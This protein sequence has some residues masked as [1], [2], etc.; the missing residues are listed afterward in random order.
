MKKSGLIFGGLLA[1]MM[2]LCAGCANTVS[3]GE[4][5]SAGVPV[6]SVTISGNKAVAVG[7]SIS[8]Q[9]TVSPSNATV[10]T[11]SWTSSNT[12]AATVS[13]SGSRATVTGVAA[14][15]A[16]IT[17]A[18]TDGSGKKA[19]WQVT[20]TSFTINPTRVLLVEGSTAQISLTGDAGG[21]SWTSSNT[22]VATVSGSGSQATVTG[23][24]AGTAVITAATKECTATCEIT[25]ESGTLP[26]ETWWKADEYAAGDITETTELGIMTAVIDN[27]NNSLTIEN[28][29]KTIE[30]IVFNARLKTNGSG[31]TSKRALKFNVSGPCTV[32]VYCAS[33]NSTAADR[34]LVLADDNGLLVSDNCAPVEAGTLVYDYTGTAGT[35][36]L[37]SG[38]RG[39][40]IYGVKIS[41]TAGTAGTVVAPSGIAV[42]KTSLGFDLSEGN[43]TSTLTATLQPADVTAGYDGIIW[44]SD[45]PAVATVDGNGKT[46]LVRA[47][48]AGTAVITATTE[49]GSFSAGCTV[50]VTGERT[51]VIRASDIPSGYASTGVSTSGFGGYGG[52]VVTVSSK[53]KLVEYAKKSGKYVIY[54][55]GMID[56]S[57]G[58]LPAEGGGSTTALDEFVKNNSNSEF[59]TYEAFKTAY[60]GACSAETDDSSSSSPESTYG[61]VLWTLNKAYKNVIQLNLTSDKTLIGLGT[62][63]G[64]K[65]GTVSIADA[66][67]IALRNLTIQ[68]A[69]DPFPHYESGDGFNA[70]HD[71]IGIQGTCSNIWIDH[72]TLKDTLY[73]GT[74][75]IS[76]GK[77]EKW[78]TYDGLCDMKGDVKNIT[79]SNCK[80]MEHDKTMLVGSSDTDGSNETRT[81]T[82]SGNYF[83]N[84]GQRLPMARNVK[85][86]IY[87]NY[88]D[89]ESS[90]HYKQQYAV[91]C[92][93]GSL[94]VAENNYFGSGIYYSFKDSDGTL[95]SSGNTDNSQKKCNTTTISSS[96]PFEI[97]YTYTVVSASEAKAVAEKFAGA[98]TCSVI[99]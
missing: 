68:D 94:I 87:N 72:C 56:M 76:D 26:A 54:I 33:G 95:Y 40:N 32:T 36:Y 66:S 25:V 15:T 12:G 92:R 70:Q 62:G 38:N 48:A 74:V 78:Q 41:T 39:I 50:T 59:E 27:A 77:S 28:S 45:N 81:L 61:S 34:P 21:V 23:V 93:A 37:Y 57:D 52:T 4:N 83:Y 82:L 97:P 91:G 22:G 16:V 20:V 60:A 53:E 17:V 75:S 8:L 71:A 85:A 6:E 2:L 79:V 80:F 13:G 19:E 98:G 86:H 90:P 9:A 11:L 24:A 73:A 67:N 69:Y 43:A 30:G 42:D 55:D 14:G 84:C 10:Q 88:Y 3:S 47:V 49:Y 99:Q 51:A 89:A 5:A 96:K 58:M 29:P 44:E 18:A 31:S 1:A 7:S 65:G 64:I 46:A 35:L 63:S